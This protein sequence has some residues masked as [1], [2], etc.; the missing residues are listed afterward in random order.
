MAWG[1][2][3]GAGARGLDDVGNG[4]FFRAV[5]HFGCQS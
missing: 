1:V 5:L 3:L 2:Y 4:G